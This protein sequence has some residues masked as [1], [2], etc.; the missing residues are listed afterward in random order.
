MY[1]NL[2]A[3]DRGSYV[4]KKKPKVD[5]ILCSII[6]NDPKVFTRKIE[7]NDKTL[8]IMNIFPYSPGHLQ[9]IPIN[10]VEDLGELKDDE[11][12]ALLKTTKRSIFL[13]RKVMRPDGFNL[14][15]NLGKAGASIPHLHIQIVPRYLKEPEI[16]DQEEIHRIY[17]KT[18]LSVKTELCDE[19]TF[20]GKECLKDREYI[21]NEDKDTFAFAYEKPYNR[22]HTVV[23]PKKHYRRFEDLPD[24]LVFKL[25]KN[26]IEI[27]KTIKE[28]YNPVGINIGIN[29]GNIPYASEHLMLHMVPRF[30]PESGFMEI[31]ANTRVSIESLDTTTR[32]LR[33]RLHRI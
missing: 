27:E 31:I 13:C 21:V 15:I 2:F 10:H 3:L 9:A 33:S 7:Q 11:L 30:E 32:R 17:L 1:E 19:E 28:E 23:S 29:E 4:G 6:K 20:E 18:G 25:F 5:C 26:V 24:D 12:K 16:K 8:V 14:G 22:G